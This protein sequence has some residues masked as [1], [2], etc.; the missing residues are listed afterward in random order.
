[1]HGMSGHLPYG[2]TAAYVSW[3]DELLL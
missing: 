1:M 2:V 3:S